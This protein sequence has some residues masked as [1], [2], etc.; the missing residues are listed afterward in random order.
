MLFSSAEPAF[1]SDMDKQMVAAGLDGSE[2][3][4]NSG[5]SWMV[6]A[7]GYIQTEP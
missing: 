5:G 6:P 1:L 3:K 4:D 7:A 2:Y